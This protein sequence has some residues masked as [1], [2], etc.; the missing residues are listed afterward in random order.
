MDMSRRDALIYG[1]ASATSLA[2]SAGE[3]FGKPNPPENGWSVSTQPAL[4]RPTHNPWNRGLSPGGS[5]PCSAPELSV[6]RAAR[7]LLGIVFVWA[8]VTAAGD[9]WR[10]HPTLAEPIIFGLLTLAMPFLVLQP[11]MG[12]GVAARKTPRPWISRGRSAAAHL[13]FGVGF[14]LARDCSLGLIDPDPLNFI[15]PN[16]LPIICPM[17]TAPPGAQSG[18]N[19]SVPLGHNST[20]VEPSRKRPISAPL[21]NSTSLSA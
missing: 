13:A 15:Y 3:C 12:A 16:A 4:Y 14:S 2:L 10:K 20:T 6:G 18:L 21:A 1:G 5:T 17:R 8:F 9:S 7:Y 19:L 11:A